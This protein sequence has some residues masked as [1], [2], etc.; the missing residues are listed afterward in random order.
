M[1]LTDRGVL[2]RRNE[3]LQSVNV[4]LG[5]RHVDLLTVDGAR[6]VE[7]GIL[8][9]SDGLRSRDDGM[10]FRFDGDL[11]ATS[12]ILFL[13]H[14]ILFPHSGVRTGDSVDLTTHIGVRT[15]NS[16]MRFLA[17]GILCRVS[18]VLPDES[19]VNTGWNADRVSLSEQAVL[20]DA[21]HRAAWIETRKAPSLP[22]GGHPPP[23]RGGAT[24]FSFGV[25]VWGL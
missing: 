3:V 19:L 9:P 11:R 17:D 7:D 5:R 21:G 22:S 8:F 4:L 2:R 15:L 24:V 20:A 13:S 23:L 10:L 25:Q 1:L 14:G 12:G 18:V 6:T 16:G